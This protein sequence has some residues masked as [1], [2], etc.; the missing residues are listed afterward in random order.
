M[1]QPA[2][3]SAVALRAKHLQSTRDLLALQERAEEAAEHRFE[4]GEQEQNALL[5]KV[6]AMVIRDKLV[7]PTSTNFE[8][9]EA[10]NGAP[11]LRLRYPKKATDETDLVARIHKHALGQLAS[12]VKIPMDYIHSLNVHDEARR[13]RTDL[14][15]QNLNE[16]YHKSDWGI[17]R[18]GKPIRFLHR[19]VG[20]ELRGFLSR[21]F[22]RHLASGPM[23]RAFV[24]AC[25]LVSARPIEAVASDVRFSLKCYLPHVFEAYPG[26]YICVGAEWTNSDFGVG[27]HL[28]S[29]SIWD[30]LRGTGAVL[31]DSISQV[32]LGSIIE[33]SD[34]EMSDETVAKEVE[35]QAGA[36]RDSVVAML[37]DKSVKR[38]LEAIKVANEQEISWATLK[39]QLSKFLY[40][41]DIE[42]IE[43]ILTGGDDIID[44]P[45]PGRSSDGT[46]IPTKW[47]AA[48][49]VST[50]AARTKDEERKIELQHEAGKLLAGLIQKEVD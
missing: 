38:L 27:K 33:D 26:Q 2:G 29:Q 50:M 8:V 4:L 39:G 22:G 5:E 16:L 34:I 19:L 44:L 17:D 32:H 3:M 42:S 36:I 31:D 14:L 11:Q 35:T 47:W 25:K 6:A 45:P 46:P 15:A 37:S 30:P 41:K 48:S 13:W 23:L 40:K 10:P 20:T 1:T 9:G 18:A 28:V 24:E 21:R 43:S 7:P 49:L 12:K